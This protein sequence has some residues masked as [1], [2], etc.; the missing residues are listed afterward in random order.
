MEMMEMEMMRH[1]GEKC[2]EREFPTGF[3]RATGDR[4]YGSGFDLEI[5]I[6]SR[7]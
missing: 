2:R 3:R 7:D 4:V 6:V 1:P 5:W